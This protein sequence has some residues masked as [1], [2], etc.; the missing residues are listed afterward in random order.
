MKS[1]KAYDYIKLSID[2]ELET[3]LVPKLLLHLFFIELNNIM[4]ILP[5]EG[6]LKEVRYAENYIIISDSNL[7]IILPPQLKNMTSRYKVMCNCECFINTKIIHS[8]LLIWKYKYNG[9]QNNWV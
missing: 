2:V 4:L 3:Q 7:H 8:Y 6:R 5:E 9:T 1:P